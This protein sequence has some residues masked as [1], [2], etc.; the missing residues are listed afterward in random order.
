MLIPYWRDLVASR[1]IKGVSKLCLELHGFQNVYNVAS[2]RRLRDAVG[3]TVG[4]ISIPA[5]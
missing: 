4:P 1:Q 3:T 5:T 2:L